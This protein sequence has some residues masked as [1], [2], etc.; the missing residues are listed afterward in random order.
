MC[1]H[2]E[3]LHGSLAQGAAARLLRKQSTGAGRCSGRGFTEAT[4]QQLPAELREQVWMDVMF[5]CGS[6]PRD[7]S[8]ATQARIEAI[9]EAN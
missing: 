7:P 5:Q 2:H 9:L 6:K 3:R 1:L 8:T 4:F